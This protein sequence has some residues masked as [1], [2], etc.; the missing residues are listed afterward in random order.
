MSS[1]FGSSGNGT[2]GPSQGQGLLLSRAF[3]PLKVSNPYFDARSCFV[4][5]VLGSISASASRR[6]GDAGNTPG[7]FL[8]ILS[9]VDDGIFSL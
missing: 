2:Q 1:L 7:V 3:R 8:N 4:A 9:T 5:Q 6:A